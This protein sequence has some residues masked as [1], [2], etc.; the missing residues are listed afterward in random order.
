MVRVVFVYP[1]D[2]RGALRRRIFGHAFFQIPAHAQ[3]AIP[4]RKDRL[5]DDAS[6]AVKAVFA[7]RPFF[8]TEQNRHVFMNFPHGQSTFPLAFSTNSIIYEKYK[9]T[10]VNPST[11]CLGDLCVNEIYWGYI[12]ADFTIF[13]T[14]QG[15]SEK[16][17]QNTPR[18][19]QAISVDVFTNK[20]GE[21]CVKIPYPFPMAAELFPVPAP[22]GTE[23]FPTPEQAARPAAAA[24]ACQASC[25]SV[26]EAR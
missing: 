16:E 21:N 1:V 5:V 12:H 7:H 13:M 8:R 11:I 10:M 19:V 3:I 24:P 14:K 9:K 26:L 6:P 15:I 22:P 23:N 17:E 20:C 2:Q 25:T 18:F 4:D